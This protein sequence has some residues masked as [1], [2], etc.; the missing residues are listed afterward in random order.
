MAEAEINT[1]L[2][3]SLKISEDTVPASTE[4]TSTSNNLTKRLPRDVFEVIAEINRKRS[5]PR[6]NDPESSVDEQPTEN[7]YEG[8]GRFRRETE[9][10]PRR[11]ES[12]RTNSETIRPENDHSIIRREYQRNYQRQRRQAPI[13]SSW[14]DTRRK[15]EKSIKEGPTLVCETML[16]KWKCESDVVEV[17]FWDV[18]NHKFEDLNNITVMKDGNPDKNYFCS[19]CKA[20]IKKSRVPT[21]ALK[22]GF[23]FP[24]K[25]A[26]IDS[27]IRLE[28]RFVS[29]R[30]VFQSIWSHKGLLGQY[31]TKGGIVNVPVNVETTNENNINTNVPV[32]T[33]EDDYDT[34]DEQ[35]MEPESNEI[36]P[37]ENEME[38]EP[39]LNAGT[40]E[41]ILTSDN[42]FTIRLAPGE[43]MTPISV[44]TDK[45]SDLLSFPKVYY[46]HKLEGSGSVSCG[47]LA[48]SVVRR[49]D[50]RAVM[51]P[52]LLLY[53]DR[54][55]LL[56]K[57]S[58]NIST[59]LRKRSSNGTD[60]IP[61]TAKDVSN[62]DYVSNLLNKDQAFKTF[63]DGDVKTE[64]EA[65]DLSYD[66]KARL[67]Q[68]DPITT[69][70][71]FDHRFRELKKTWLDEE[72]PFAGFSTN[73]YFF[74]VEF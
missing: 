21:I 48:K 15:Y 34:V 29:P 13:V 6:M 62:E 64:A 43:G 57:M 58:S 51:R 31:K 67:L 42:D 20:S 45:D 46:G 70:R 35:G 16:S 69:A 8:R 9:E 19:T 47:N 56:T 4:H 12:Q 36:N 63:S 39:S 53:M 72:G 2:G 50:R 26:C 7:T 52:A 65:E 66:E 17:A 44:L 71:Y 55:C 32:Q 28:E 3:E 37:A 59:I 61:F 40:T 5:R 68:A 24:D 25:V 1:K 41:S 10:S 60:G 18:D 23:H 11:R 73:E 54:K 49:F 27:L 30:H 74:R 22:N 33:N 38:D 14:E